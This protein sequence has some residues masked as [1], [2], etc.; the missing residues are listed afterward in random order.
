MQ[1][2]SENDAMLDEGMLLE[3]ARDARKKAY[4]PYS[5]FL[6]GAA[7]LDDQGKLHKGCNVENASYPQG[8]C[9]EAGAIAAMILAEGRQI[10]ALAVVGESTNPVTPC[11]GCRQKIRE[12]A[13]PTTPIL[14][15]DLKVLRLRQTLAEL[16]P[17]SFGPEYL[18]NEPQ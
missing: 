9:A 5:R 3:A 11:G 14:I 1:S 8:T 6:V 4:A 18:L 13:K 16:L 12:F 10:K 17:H 2:M 15:G 7:I